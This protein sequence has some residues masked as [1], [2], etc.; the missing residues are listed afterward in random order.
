MS[1]SELFK[2]KHGMVCI[3]MELYDPKHMRIGGQGL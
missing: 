3:I 1:S 2:W